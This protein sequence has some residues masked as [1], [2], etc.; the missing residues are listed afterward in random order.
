RTAVDPTAPTSQLTAQDPRGFP[1]PH[2]WWEALS[3]YQLHLVH[4]AGK[5]NPADAPS[6][7]PDYHPGDEATEP[8]QLL[9]LSPQGQSP[10]GQGSEESRKRRRRRKGDRRQIVGKD[11]ST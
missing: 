10:T 8:P 11:L 4:Q 5:N 2:S 3:G 7:R 6:R 9:L 1:N